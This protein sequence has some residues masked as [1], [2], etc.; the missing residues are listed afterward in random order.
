MSRAA[1]MPRGR[2]FSIAHLALLVP[3]VALVIG[4]WGPIADNSFLWHVR[5]GTLQASQGHVLTED[6]FSFTMAGE[7]WLTQ[8]WLVELLYAW[9]ESFSGLGFVP[10]MILVVSTLTFAGIGLAAYHFSRSVPATV[11][12]LV[13][14]TIALLSFLVPRPVLFS[15]LLMTLVILAWERRACR[16]TL[17]LLFWI[18]ASVH[19]SF[20][21]GLVYLGLSL[22]MR[23]EWRELPTAFVAG[24]STLV[25]A[26]GLGVVSFLLEF[27][28]NSDA[29]QYLTEWR[30]PELGE[31][32]FLPLLGGVVFIVVGAFRN[33]ILPRHLWLLVPFL[34]LGMTSVRAIP[35]AWLG[36]VPL[37]ALSLSGLTI[38]SR[39]G[40]RLRLAAIFGVVVLL[41]PFLLVEGS[42]LSEERF[43]IEL[44]AE[45][46]DLPTFHDD[47]VG[48]YLIW[49]SGP[50]RQ[51]YIDDRAELYGWRMEEFVSIRRGDIDWEPVFERDGVG[52]VLLANTERLVADLLEAGWV[53]VDRDDFFVVLLPGA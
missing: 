29:L 39:A 20:T 11:F 26:H 52:Q 5:A 35:P 43:P 17:P 37:V 51:V 1:E 36:L 15:Y 31:P 9:A 12:V 44:A 47:R 32:L 25:T 38:G 21:I 40:L 24:L 23:R 13:L 33:L 14:S 41:L 16:W 53:E 4:A 19:A 7:R 27:G 34:L 48:G 28:A 6:P 42:E 49:A 30:R 2:R 45:L 8:S 3:W 22:I 10:Y 46:E 50:E 18:W